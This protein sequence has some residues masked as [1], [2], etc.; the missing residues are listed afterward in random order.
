[1]DRLITP[2]QN[3]QMIAVIGSASQIQSAFF[4]QPMSCSTPA[5]K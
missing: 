4:H 3:A 1:V 5:R 2:A